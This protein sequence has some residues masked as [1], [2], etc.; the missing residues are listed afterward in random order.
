[1]GFVAGVSAVL[2][3]IGVLAA[4]RQVR[5]HLRLRRRLR[6]CHAEIERLTVR[7]AAAE[8]VLDQTHGRLVVVRDLM[9][10]RWSEA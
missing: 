2:L 9:S 4:L 10:S 8:A 5:R 7:K 3:A 1:M 6:F